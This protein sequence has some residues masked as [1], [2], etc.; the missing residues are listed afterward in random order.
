MIKEAIRAL[1][2]T[3]SKE[4]LKPPSMRVSPGLWKALFDSGRLK[5]EKR[6]LSGLPKAIL[7]LPYLDNAI[8]TECDPFL[9]DFEYNLLGGQSE[10]S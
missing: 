7:E 1:D 6:Q 4:S 2:E 9:R 5:Y 3:L 8:Y 10:R